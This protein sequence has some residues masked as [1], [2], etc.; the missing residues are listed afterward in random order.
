[1]PMLGFRSYRTAAVTLAGLELVH[2]IRKRQF[3]FGPGL[4]EPLVTEEAVGESPCV[5]S[6]ARVLLTQFQTGNAPNPTEIR[7]S[8]RVCL[9]IRAAL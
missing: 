9:W 1:M 6:A 5:R 2:R 7:S 8:C 3:K 4:V